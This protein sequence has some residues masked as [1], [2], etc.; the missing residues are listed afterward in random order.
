MLALI[1]ALVALG[2]TPPAPPAVPLGVRPLF[3]NETWY[4]DAKGEA[5]VYEG[6]LEIHAAEGRI[7]MPARFNSFQLIS[8]EDGKPIIRQ[9]HTA[10]KDHLLSAFISHNVKLTA[11]LVETEVDGVKR[12]ELWPAQIDVLGLAP[13]GVIAEWKIIARTSSALPNRQFL[14]PPQPVVIRNGKQAAE[15]LGAGGA[16]ADDVATA[17]LA[18]RFGGNIKIDWS[19]QMVVGL[20]GGNRGGFSKIDIS[21]ITFGELGLDVHWEISNQNL[22]GG[23]NRVAELALINLFDGDIR[24]LQKGSTRAQV[25]PGVHKK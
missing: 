4:K 16:T 24:F 1:W 25:V 2:Q 21:K 8:L 13:A 6:V 19:K 23:T 11:K 22:G 10:G 20:S 5:K 14:G 15:F 18:Q 3:A 17:T 7:G 12:A 9:I